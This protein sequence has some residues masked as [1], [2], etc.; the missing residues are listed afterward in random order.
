MSD[1]RAHPS[2]D[3]VPVGVKAAHAWPL[4]AEEQEMDMATHQEAVA[5]KERAA[6]AAAKQWNYV[7]VVDGQA[8]ANF[9][10]LDPAQGAGEAIASDRPDGQIDVWYY[11]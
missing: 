8:V 10:N 4:H 7:V 9:L 3:P 5:H 1:P 6:R 11:L 2:S